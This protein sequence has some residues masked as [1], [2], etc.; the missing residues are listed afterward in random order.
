MIRSVLTL[1]AFLTALSIVAASDFEDPVPFMSSGQPIDVEHEGHA[2]PFV[3][4]IDGD[5]RD[6]LLVGEA[7]TSRLRIYRNT[8]NGRDHTLDGFS[9]L[10]DGGKDGCISPPRGTF[11][12]QLVDFDGDGDTDIIAGNL[13]GN[14]ILFERSNKNSFLPGRV[15]TRPNGD[16]LRLGGSAMVFAVDW[17]ADEDLDLIAGSSDGLFLV[18]NQGTRTSFEPAEREF[19]EADGEPVADRVQDFCPT[20]VDWDSDDRLDI[21]CGY[22]DGSVQWFRNTGTPTEPQL[23][24]AGVLIPPPA[25]GDDR[26][27][28][29][30]ICVTDWNQDGHLDLVLGDN[31]EKFFR[32]LTDRERK[33]RADAVDRQHLLLTFWSRQFRQL[34]ET[35]SRRKAEPLKARLWE[36]R[37]RDLHATLAKINRAREKARRHVESLGGGERVHGRVWLFLRKP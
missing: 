2:A 1:N 23:S 36:A 19:I 29:A 4:D 22:R 6:D 18:R 5:G 17:D 3:G 25:K 37:M 28:T 10:L 9:L 14:V 13:F 32:A 8:G 7:Y 11:R 35:D 20:V 27:K 30:R 26:G 24:R 31:G 16:R 21:L 15:L 33:D 12:P 34:R